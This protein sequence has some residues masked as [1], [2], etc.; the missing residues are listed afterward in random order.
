M[1]ASIEMDDHPPVDRAALSDEQLAE[2]IVSRAYAGE[3]QRRRAPL[4]RWLGPAMRALPKVLAIVTVANGLIGL[5]A[6]VA[7]W[8]R[9][10]FGEAA[11]RPL[12]TAYSFICP[13]RDSHTWFIGDTPMAMEQRMVAMYVAFGVAGAAYLLWERVRRPLP[14]WAA[15]LAI[16]PA[17]IDVAIST[18]GIRPSTEVSRLWTGTLGSLG[19]VFWAYPRFDAQLRVVR[20]RVEL[21]RR[22]EASAHADERRLLH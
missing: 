6:I 18:L 17:L 2:L 13:Q 7:P 10:A 9:M 22:A 14:V 21:L 15:L 12:Y 8:L 4:P 1:A 11:V 20:E 3:R 16:A 19:I 5:L